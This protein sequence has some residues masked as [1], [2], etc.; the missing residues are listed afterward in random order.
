M[1]QIEWAMSRICTISLS[2][3]NNATNILFLQRNSCTGESDGAVLW[4]KMLEPRCVW[5]AVTSVC[6]KTREFKAS[7]TSLWRYNREYRR[8][9]NFVVYQ[10]R[11]AKFGGL[12]YFDVYFSKSNLLLKLKTSMTSLWRHN[13]C[14]SERPCNFAIF[15]RRSPKFCKLYYFDAFS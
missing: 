13:W 4:P 3:W 5:R 12:G 7:M 1:R 11:R 9:C 6:R 2:Y 15:D 10:G 14:I 8:L